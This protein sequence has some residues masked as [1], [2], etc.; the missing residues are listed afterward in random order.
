MVQVVGPIEANVVAFATIFGDQ[1]IVDYISCGP[2]DSEG[3][4]SIAAHMVSLRVQRF[5]S[6]LFY[7]QGT[8]GSSAYVMKK[9]VHVS[10]FPSLKP[11]FMLR[12]RIQL[13]GIAVCTA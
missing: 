1:L 10:A 3:E 4:S 5:A 2:I 6:T 8:F 11:C 13:S 7:C 12:G 9:N